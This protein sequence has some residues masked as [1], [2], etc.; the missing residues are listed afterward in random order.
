MDLMIAAGRGDELASELHG[1]AEASGRHVR[2]MELDEASRF[3]SIDVG[4]TVAVEPAIPLFLRVPGPPAVRE[5][6]GAA[7]LRGEQA[8]TLW[9]AGAL[10][11][12]PCVNRPGH[13]GFAGRSSFSSSATFL[14]AGYA[15]SS[16]ETFSR[17]APDLSSDR[18]WAIQNTVTHRTTLWPQ[19]PETPGPYRSREV[20]PGST[21]EVVAVVNGQ[22]WRISDRPLG[23]LDLEQRSAQVIA[24]LGLTFG[25]AIWAISRDGTIA[26]AARFEA[27]PPFDYIRPRWDAVGPA[28]LQELGG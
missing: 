8:G 25:A 23:E 3:F 16:T 5:S 7:F 19:R 15:S 18:T 11:K 2:R 1:L 20:L 13:H 24:A 17:E 26:V 22:A 6:F 27:Y 9:A 4:G 14:R 28:L 21:Y 10:M 12:S